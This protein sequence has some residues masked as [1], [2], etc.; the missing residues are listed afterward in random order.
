ML[1]IHIN[2]HLN[3]SEH[4]NHVV[5]KIHSGNYMLYNLRDYVSLPVL[6]S[7]YHAFIS[8]HIV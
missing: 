6:L 2:E 1:D 7:V 5:K 4:V 8:S 3:W